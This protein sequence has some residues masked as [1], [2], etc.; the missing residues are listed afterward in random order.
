MGRQRAANA[1]AGVAIS[2]DT[3]NGAEGFLVPDTTESRSQK[4]ARSSFTAKNMFVYVSAHGA[5]SGVNIYLRK[6]GANSA[7]TVSIAASTTG[8]FEDTTNT[9]DYVATDTYN[10]FIDHGGGAGSITLTIV[11]FEL[12]QPAAA[13]RRVFV[14]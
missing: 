3:Y 5:S 11:G 7:L 9:V 2:S 4:T 1:V 14:T 10:W 8:V 12:A 13:G 6:N